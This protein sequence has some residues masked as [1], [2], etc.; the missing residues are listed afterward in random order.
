ML[1]T[2]RRSAGAQQ[3]CT[4]A[5]VGVHVRGGMRK[6]KHTRRPGR[7][8]GR[9]VNFSARI[10]RFGFRTQLPVP[11][12]HVR[13]CC[14]PW[15]RPC[16]WPRAQEGAAGAAGWSSSWA[17]VRWPR[18][19]AWEGASAARRVAARREARPGAL[20]APGGV[21]AVRSVRGYDGSLAGRRR[22]CSHLRC[23]ELGNRSS[24]L[25]CPVPTTT[26]CMGHAAL[27]AFRGQR[28][29]LRRVR[30]TGRTVAKAAAAAWL[31]RR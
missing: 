25:A 2:I 21:R 8:L 27:H 28:L 7:A 19:L 15:A 26:N 12:I 14:L 11:R 18:V 17:L 9:L 23:N 4:C 24:Y 22:T 5:P 20:R 3:S 16:G 31:L 10:A 29:R 13:L 6:K 30:G 1:L